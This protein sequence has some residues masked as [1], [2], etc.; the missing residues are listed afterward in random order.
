MNDDTNILAHLEARTRLDAINSKAKNELP[1]VVKLQSGQVY[2]GFLK[3][4]PTSPTD[5]IHITFNLKH[6]I[7]PNFPELWAAVQSGQLKE[8]EPL[9]IGYS[10]RVKCGKTAHDIFS[11][12]L[13]DSTKP[14]EQGE[15]S[16][17]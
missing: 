10:G 13:S 3:F 14:L 6:Y 15:N 1:K 8:G 16:N 7:M 17:G 5:P 4:A 9:A 2:S 11:L 12:H